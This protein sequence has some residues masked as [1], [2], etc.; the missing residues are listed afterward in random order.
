MQTYKISTA[1]KL[2]QFIII[3]NLSLSAVDAINSFLVGIKKLID[4][5]K[6]IISKFLTHRL[7]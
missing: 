5:F 2:N 7:L 1:F 3:L 6:E 4:K